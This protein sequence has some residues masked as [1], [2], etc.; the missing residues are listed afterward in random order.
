[1]GPGAEATHFIRIPS[2]PRGAQ[3]HQAA[4]Q[5]AGDLCQLG[6]AGPLMPEMPEGLFVASA[7]SII[8]AVCVYVCVYVVCVFL[9]VLVFACVSVCACPISVSVAF[10]VH[11]PDPCERVM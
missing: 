4:R 8:T 10:G 5:A 2:E 11:V 1:M 9:C 6:M 7:N 3:A